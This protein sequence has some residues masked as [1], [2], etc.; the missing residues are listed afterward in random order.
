MKTTIKRPKINAGITK[1][2]IKLIAD[3]SKTKT[4]PILNKNKGVNRKN[5]PKTKIP[6]I[7]PILKI[8]CR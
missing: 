1:G 6:F 8:Y 3:H 5:N 7:A 2:K 4:T